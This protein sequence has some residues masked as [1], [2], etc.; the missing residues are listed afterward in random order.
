MKSNQN[1]QKWF[2]KVSRKSVDFVICNKL[3]VVMA[4]IELDGKTHEAEDRQKA[5][6]VKDEALQ[7]AGI[8]ILRIAAS[9]IPSVEE[10]KAL[11]KNAVF[12]S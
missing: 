5:D 9:K 4:C 8:P 6:G 1:W 11:L 2:N 10:I 12:L 3:F 7:T